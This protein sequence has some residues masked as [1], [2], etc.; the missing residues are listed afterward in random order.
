[1]VYEHQALILGFFIILV[2]SDSV[3]GCSCQEDVNI[4]EV[5]K[6]YRL[7]FEGAVLKRI[8]FCLFPIA[9]SNFLPQ[10]FIRENI[11]KKYLFGVTSLA[12]HA[13]GISKKKKY[14]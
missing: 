4:E 9:D 11:R 8:V 10:K 5:E 1:M 6:E 12:R 13:V 3:C 2:F 7:I 14:I